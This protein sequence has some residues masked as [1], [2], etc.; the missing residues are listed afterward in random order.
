LRV[1][2][3]GRKRIYTEFA[4]SAED[5]EQRETAETVSKYLRDR[6]LEAVA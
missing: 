5:A 4:E 3:I 2:W 6:T 1:Q